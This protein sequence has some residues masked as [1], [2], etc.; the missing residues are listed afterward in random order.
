MKNIWKIIKISRPLHRYFLG[1]SF[2]ILVTALLTQLSPL[3]I[4]TIVDQIELQVTTQNG[5][6][7]NLYFWVGAFFVANIL[8]VLINAVTQ[9][10]GDYISSRLGKYLTEEFYRKIFTLPQKYFDSEISGKIVNQLTRG[11]LSIQSFATSSTNF[12]LPALLQSFFTIFVLAY[13]D[14][15]IGIL[16]FSI[17]PIYVGISRYSTIVW[18]KREVEK[19]KREDTARGRI[20]EVISN[21]RLVKSFNTQRQEWN[22]ISKKY[23]QINEIYDKQS[24]SYHLLNFVR[25][26]GLEFIIFVIMVMT[27]A[28]T[29]TGKFSLGEM[30]L[31]LQLLNM[32]RRPLFAMSFILEQVQRAESG[33][34]EYFEIIELES[35]EKFSSLKS[36]WRKISK[37][38]IEFKNVNFSY[39][40]GGEV[41]Q[42][43]SFKLDKQETIAL[44]GH[45]G[46]GKSTLINLILKFYDPSSG[47]I[48][49]KDE[50]YKE[51]S[52]STIRN[53]ISLVFQDNELFS[54]TVKENVA[55]GLPKAKDADIVKALKQANAWEFVSKLPKGLESEIGERGVKLS[56]GQK[57]RIQIARAILRDA[58]ILILDEAT[59]SLDSKSEKLVQD[60]L[61]KL[62][63][64]R[65]VI[66]IAHRFSTI[67]D[68]DRILVVNSGTIVDSGTSKELSKKDGIYAELLRYQI[69]GNKKLLSQ[70]DIY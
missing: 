8:N 50:S 33:S 29:F 60:A 15:F 64:N 63:K 53:Q 7:Q 56:G 62:F 3:I 57:Q 10:A 18:G 38:T 30:V 32:L 21:I 59:S 35:T 28:Q 41:I 42:N 61:D 69:E 68:A 46:A 5:N 48:F 17:F 27:F 47:E 11:I 67:Q 43:V 16:A 12:I 19:N 51:L 20:Q 37:P 49:L 40:E 4:K 54:S 65:L 44:V 13:Y 45:S 36:K 14:L 22:F 70:Y 1:A 52:H 58:P 23:G 9:R 2:L 6:I 34:K 31:I 24:L 39:D 26:F 55:Y 66:I 25:N